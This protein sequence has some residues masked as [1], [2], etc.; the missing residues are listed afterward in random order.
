M[1]RLGF[2]LIEAA[3][4]LVALALLATVVAPELAARRE[5]SLAAMMRH[6]LLRFA[7]AQES[8]F[9]DH[10]VYSADVAV[11]VQRGYALSPGVSVSIREATRTGFSVVASHPETRVRCFLFVRGAAPVGSAKSP[12]VVHCS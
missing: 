3:I 4:V 8:Y 11:L 9:Y 1:S 12:G 5:R 7:A 6:D 10:G 2:A